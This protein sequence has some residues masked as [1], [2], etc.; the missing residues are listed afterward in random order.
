MPEPASTPK[1][2]LTV[3]GAIV[4]GVGAMVGAGIFALLGQAGAVAGSAV[5]IS[6][7]LAGIMTAALGYALVKF[8]MRWPSSGGIIVYLQHGY[9]SRRLVGVAAWLGY[10]TTIVVVCA[11]VAS[12]F[13]DYAAAVIADAPSGGWLSKLCAAAL[14]VFA[15]W[16][17]VAGPRV[18]DRFQTVIVGLLLVVFAV[19]VVGTLS[20]IDVSRLA[21]ST[22]PPASDILA[23]IALTFFAFL[24]FAVIS[25]AGGDLTRPRR[26]LPVAMYTSLAITTLLYVAV[27]LGVF[28]TLSVDQ[29]V[30]AGPRALAVAAEPALGQAGYVMMT[31]AA[32]LATGSSVTAT[33]YGARGLTETLATTGMFPAVFGPGTRLGRNGGLLIT[34]ALTVA[35]VTVLDVGALASVGSGVSLA[36]FL[37]VAVAAFRLRAELRASAALTAVSVAIA[38]V[39]LVGFVVN[40]FTTQRRS[41]WVMM[42]L[43]VLAVVVDELWTR[44][45]RA[46][47]VA[48]VPH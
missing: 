32:L 43:V 39:V 23:S 35:F 15:A 19:F 45:R 14:V 34:A 46:T 6:F 11:M 18:V 5:W 28:G 21:P 36:V 33:L 4:I 29:V 22:Y 7:L 41:F 16:L 37:L 8:A 38:G 13:G 26:D 9:R 20:Q 31:V 47:V 30:E 48:P 2:Q 40:L 25:F 17:T 42:A 1:A 10:L 27:S 12:S 3:R 24:G 44:R